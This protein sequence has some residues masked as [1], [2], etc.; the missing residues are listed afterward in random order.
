MTEQ[1]LVEQI[2]KLAKG[3]DKRKAI[4]ISLIAD[5][6]FALHDSE[7]TKIY[8]KF[9]RLHKKDWYWHH[10]VRLALESNDYRENMYSRI[11]FLLSEFNNR[12]DKY[13]R[14]RV[15]SGRYYIP[16]EISKINRLLILYSKFLKIYRNILSRIHFEYPSKEYIGRP[17]GKVNWKKTIVH[18]KNEFPI[19]FISNIPRKNFNT[20]ENVLLIITAH[21]LHR[22][23]KRILE[24]PFIEPLQK[25]IIERLNEIYFKTELIIRQ[26]PFQE[27]IEES[28]KYLKLT[29][30]PP[31]REIT[32]IENNVRQRILEKKIRN[33]SYLELI[34]WINQYRELAI[35]TIDNKSPTRHIL[36]SMENIDT[37]YEIWI[38]VEFASYLQEKGV[39]EN[40]DLDSKIPN[41]QFNHQN[42][43]IT[44]WYE[45]GFK[46]TDEFVWAK[47]HKPDFTAM[48]DD[49]VLGVF[50]AKN[51]SK[52][53]NISDTWNTILAYMNNFDTSVGVLF[54]PHYPETWDEVHTEIPDIIKKE[55]LVPIVDKIC[56]DVDM[57]NKML[58]KI[59]DKKWEK[60]SPDFFEDNFQSSEYFD[61]LK[62]ITSKEEWNEKLDPGRKNIIN[63]YYDKIEKI[64]L[65]NCNGLGIKNFKTRCKQNAHKKWDELDD[66]FKKNIPFGFE[67]IHQDRLLQN[68]FH[69]D[70]IYCRTRLSPKEDYYSVIMKQ[71]VFE[72][73]YQLITN[74]IPK[75]LSI[76]N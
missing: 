3:S 15:E 72:K 1:E 8:L 9:K 42:Y 69:K 57:R 12:Y 20:Y 63:Q 14:F 39:L 30:D 5:E 53:D 44:F 38:F 65:K 32:E 71:R 45:K 54:Y 50:D 36:E 64:M 55:F 23:S 11:V 59:I 6:R 40:L 18:S 17:K 13:F 48:I 62:K 74:A 16:N 33:P 7:L 22:E 46:F 4:P 29:F 37:L 47:D 34:N 25:S 70:Q 35:K 19:E 31:S 73:I 43:K 61:K 2:K 66:E 51:Y 68:R 21:E 60:L 26:F 28:E 67:E 49:K 76:D 10:F 24:I 75:T 52:D 58:D 41:I 56:D 27:V